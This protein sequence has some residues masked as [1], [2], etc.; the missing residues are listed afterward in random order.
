MQ[1]T[2]GVFAMIRMLF[3]FTILG[4]LAIT[5]GPVVLGLGVA[6]LPFALVGFAIWLAVQAIHHGPRAVGERMYGVG[7]GVYEHAQ[8]VAGGPGRFYGGCCQVARQTGQRVGRMIRSALGFVSPILGGALVGGFLGAAGGMHYHDLA[9]RIPVGVLVGGCI[10]LATALL[11][12]RPQT[13]PIVLETADH[14]I[15]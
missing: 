5:V 1:H 7:Q 6:M 3:L 13:K 2:P 4:F 14:R 15:A 10:G 8:R 9:V 12:H 11:W